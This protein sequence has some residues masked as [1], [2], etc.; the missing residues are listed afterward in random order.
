ML[1]DGRSRALEARNT[2]A[3]RKR[4]E[5]NAAQAEAAAR[6]IKEQ[7]RKGG[8]AGPGSGATGAADSSAEGVA[9]AS[10]GTSPASS[11]RSASSSV[12][13][14]QEAMDVSSSSPSQLDTSRS[15]RS[16]PRHGTAIAFQQPS[17][18][19]PQSTL[20]H[21]LKLQDSVVNN[22]SKQLCVICKELAVYL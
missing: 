13:I 11:T 4:A 21:V 10:A 18:P 15:T 12:T 1:L 16:N 19:A 3:N 17:A 8:R 9:S 14:K 22:F 2:H 7:Q 20:L 6:A 5:R